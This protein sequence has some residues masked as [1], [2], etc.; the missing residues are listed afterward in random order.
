MASQ[1]PQLTLFPDPLHIRRQGVGEPDCPASHKLL[2]FFYQYVICVILIWNMYC[3]VNADM[4]NTPVHFCVQ[5]LLNICPISP[6][7][8]KTIERV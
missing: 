5:G 1:V 3:T 4:N 7:E 8:E 6:A 2:I